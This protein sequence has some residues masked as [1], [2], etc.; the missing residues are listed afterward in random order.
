MIRVPPAVGVVLFEQ[1]NCHG[2]RP[3]CQ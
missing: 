3:P 2:D 1:R